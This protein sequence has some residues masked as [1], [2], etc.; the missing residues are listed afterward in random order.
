MYV[1]FRILCGTLLFEFI[2]K[3]CLEIIEWKEND[4][5]PPIPPGKIKIYNIF[6]LKNVRY[7]YIFK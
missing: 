3:L 1:Y 5:D 2:K 4:H 7:Y 6:N